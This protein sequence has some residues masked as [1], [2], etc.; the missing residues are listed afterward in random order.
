MNALHTPWDYYDRPADAWLD[1]HWLR[2]RP[3]LYEKA[4][5][6]L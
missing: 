6:T 1:E 2:H 5:L 3:A 4:G